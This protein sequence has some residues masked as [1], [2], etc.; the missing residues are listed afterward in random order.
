MTCPA[1]RAQTR[2]IRSRPDAAGTTIRRRRACPECAARISTVE[3]IDPAICDG[4]TRET[5]A[6]PDRGGTTR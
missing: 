3:R 2:V 5:F 6:H 4:D 1:C